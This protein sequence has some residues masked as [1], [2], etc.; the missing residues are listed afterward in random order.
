[1]QTRI[2]PNI[3]TFH[4]VRC[5]SK[6]INFIITLRVICIG[7]SLLRQHRDIVKNVQSTKLKMESELLNAV[8]YLKNL[9]KKNVT[10]TKIE[11]FMRMKELFPCKEDLYNIIDNFIEKGLIQV[12]GDGENGVF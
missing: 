7:K 2:T 1:M 8:N 6:T 11:A 9:R 3:D 5:T 10:F 12:R 4:T